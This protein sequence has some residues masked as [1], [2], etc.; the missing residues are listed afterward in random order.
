[1]TLDLRLQTPDGVK[2]IANSCTAGGT[3]PPRTAYKNQG[4]VTMP[5]KTAT[6]PSS[7]CNPP[8]D[9]TIVKFTNGADANDPNA[10]GVPNIAIGGAI[11]WTDR[12]TNTGGATVARA[13]VAVTDDHAGVTPVFDSE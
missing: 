8:P 1:M 13:N 5:G 3:Q 9:V 12:V 7:Y 10:A 2:T 6:D 11:T 4:T